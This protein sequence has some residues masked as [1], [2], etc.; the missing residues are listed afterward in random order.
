VKRGW[1]IFLFC[2]LSALVA[3]AQEAVRYSLAGE[4]A[5]AAR[6]RARTDDYYNIDLDPI[7]LRFNSS[8]SAEY[9]DNVNLSEA[10]PAEDF[11]LRPMVGV[12]AF[13]PVS[14]RNTL[15]FALNFGYEHYFHDSRPSRFIVAGDENSGL[16]FDVFVG[17]FA[18]NLHDTFSLTQ[19]T[20]Q[21]PSISGIADLFR[22]ENTAGVGVTWDL[23]KLRLDA[24]YDHSNYVPLDKFY[25]YLNHA[26][27]FGTLRASALVHPA[28]TTGVEAGGGLTQY[29]DPRLSDN[30]HAS[31]G[32][33]AKYQ[34]S[35]ALNARA[36]V[37]YVH[38]W[39]DRSLYLTNRTDQS[40]FYA[41]VAIEHAPTPR[42]RQTLNIGQSLGTDINSSPIR[43]FYVRYSASLDIIRN[44]SLN[45]HLSYELGTE[46]FGP[47][48][49]DFTRYG[50]GLALGRRITRKLTGVLDYELLIKDST[51][52][53]FDYTQNRLVLTLV[54]QF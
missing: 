48:R 15:D 40:S 34:V 25:D 16:F 54:Y 3:T 41:D 5:A 29:P 42:T 21:D 33:F 13:W 23:Y 10:R 11:I 20:S 22:L 44:W 7:K 37:G 6:K 35:E 31:I 51:V 27:D 18:I 52:A 43:T 46:F 2:L 19:E 39:F 26:S 47:S 38:Y 1:L 30:E 14:E 8:L 4:E 17:D 24:G 28:L 12:R 36:S 45:P 49:E 32:P 9:N 50:V 53:T